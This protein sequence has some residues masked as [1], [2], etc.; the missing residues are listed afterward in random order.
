M[1]RNLTL[2]SALAAAALTAWPG[3]AHAAAADDYFCSEVTTRH[4]NR[5][6]EARHCFP[7]PPAE[8]FV[9][10][11]VIHDTRDPGKAYHCGWAEVVHGDGLDGGECRLQ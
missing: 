8:P 4:D 9:H 6:V 11:L 7:R 10:D 3:A 2:A 5:D 1:R